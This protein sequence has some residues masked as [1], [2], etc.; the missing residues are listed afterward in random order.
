MKVRFTADFD[1][2][3]PEFKGR[4]TLFRPSGWTGTVK[5]DHGEAAIA[6]GKAESMEPDDGTQDVSRPAPRS[7]GRRASTAGR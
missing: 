2:D 4:V 7:A 3:V 5:R 1:W 6:A